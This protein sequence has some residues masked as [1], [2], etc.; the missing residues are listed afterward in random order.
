MGLIRAA[1]VNGVTCSVRGRYVAL[2]EQPDGAE[3]PAAYNLKSFKNSTLLSLLCAG[4]REVV[5]PVKMP[6]TGKYIAINREM[7]WKWLRNVLRNSRGKA[8][9][10]KV[11]I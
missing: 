6:K 11:A 5:G 8:N 9:L 10:C 2:A 7:Y 1:I 3:T 4:L